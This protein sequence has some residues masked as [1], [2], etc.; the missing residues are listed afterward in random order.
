MVIHEPKDYP[1]NDRI[2]AVLKREGVSK[3]QWTTGFFDTENK[4]YRH[5]DDR[6]ISAPLVVCW[7]DYPDPDRAVMLIGA[8]V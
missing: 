8:G 3:P 1:E 4:V 2:I 7:S 5:E 6:P